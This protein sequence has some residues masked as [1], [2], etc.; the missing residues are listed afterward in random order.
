[1]GPST[2]RYQVAPIPSASQIWQSN[3]H[4]QEL[5]IERTIRCNLLRECRGSAIEVA[6][7]MPYLFEHSHSKLERTW[8]EATSGPN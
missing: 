7:D 1:M 4:E 2:I 3:P 8:A 6:I 5:C